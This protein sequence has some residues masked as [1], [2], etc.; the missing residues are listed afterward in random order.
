MENKIVLKVSSKSNPNSV[1][2]AIAGG[3][4][5]NKKVELQAIG[6]GAVNQS[7]KAI[8]IARSF[9]A[10]ISVDLSCIPAFCTVMVGHEEKTGMKFIIKEDK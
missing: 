7:I 4:Q 6:A 5:E 1:A 8:A 10:A 2:G 9:V 3:L